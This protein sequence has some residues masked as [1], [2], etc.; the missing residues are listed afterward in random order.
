MYDLKIKVTEDINELDRWFGP[1]GMALNWYK[2]NEIHFWNEHSH[3]K[4][5]ELCI[6]NNK[7]KKTQKTLFVVFSTSEAE[8][9]AVS[10]AAQEVILIK[11]LANELVKKKQ[12]EP[13]M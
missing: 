12:E 8:Y 13:T 9:V 11:L 2:T 5:S 1:H 3:T 7:I 4:P 10:C 6:A